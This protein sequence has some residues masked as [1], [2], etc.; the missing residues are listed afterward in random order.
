MPAKASQEGRVLLQRLDREVV[1]LSNMAN[2][3]D[4]LGKL[5]EIN[6]LPV[7]TLPDHCRKVAAA[8]GVRTE[9]NFGQR[10]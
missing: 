6:V 3:L 1:N 8:C 2:A 5:A 7:T 10:R 9:R 4:E